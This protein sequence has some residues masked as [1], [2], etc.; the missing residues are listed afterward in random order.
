MIT[1]MGVTFS[2]T[3]LTFSHASAQIGHRVLAKFMDDKGN[4]LT[5][6]TFISTFSFC[7]LILRS[8]RSGD[9]DDSFVPHLSVLVALIL[10]FFCILVLI[11]FFNHAPAQMSATAAINSIA[12]NLKSSIADI[13][14][15]KVIDS[16]KDE[17]TD[18]T[19]E[20]DTN[21]F[22]I[23]S[24]VE[25]GY[26]QFFEEARVLAW[27]QK[28]NIV[29]EIKCRVGDFLGLGSSLVKIHILRRRPEESELSNLRKVF[30]LGR[31]RNF[32]QNLVFHLDLLIEVSVRALS[33]G[34]KDPFTAIE[35]LNALQK[36]SDEFRKFS[37]PKNAIFDKG[38]EL[39]LIRSYV[40]HLKL[41]SYYLNKLRP[42]VSRDLLVSH[43]MFQ[44]IGHLS[45]SL[46]EV[47]DIKFF[48]DQA[49]LL[50]AQVE[51]KNSDLERLEEFKREMCLNYHFF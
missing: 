51:E 47:I 44:L 12:E 28:N 16:P 35:C 30:I 10:A 23:L 34:G 15:L 33:S 48:R 21:S 29:A 1:V 37:I 7:L 45:R 14:P 31:D 13:Y 8:V 39:R 46:E 50:M 36:I 2:I 4:Q 32:K 43:R 27:A 41:V 19:N 5:L 9:G 38:G 24:A 11:F 49:Q 22:L 18:H 20:E 40:T 3:L 42:Y 17:E 6:G 25:S 26:L